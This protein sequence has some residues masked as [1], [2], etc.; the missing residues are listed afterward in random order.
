MNKS[1]AARIATGRVLIGSSHGCGLHVTLGMTLATPPSQGKP[2]DRRVRQDE[3]PEDRSD[4]GNSHSLCEQT[5]VRDARVLEGW[6]VA[7]PRGTVATEP[8]GY[9]QGEVRGAPAE[10]VP[11]GPPPPQA[12]SLPRTR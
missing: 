2:D 6:P 11:V 1:V 8:A 4:Q 9:G 7:R 3:Q 12:V 10:S 5:R